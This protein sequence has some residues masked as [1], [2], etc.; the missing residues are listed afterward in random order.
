MECQKVIVV[1]FVS[2]FKSGASAPS[3][4]LPASVLAVVSS[5]V[6]PCSSLVVFPPPH[7]VSAIAAI[8]AARIDAI[9]FELPQPA[10]IV[11][12]TA[13]V[14]NTLINFFF[15]FFSSFFIQFSILFS[16]TGISP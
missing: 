6:A 13:N 16:V 14:S 5:V 8:E 1:S 9:A 15:I 4:V 3:A 10:N 12:A 2:W 11:P 7:P